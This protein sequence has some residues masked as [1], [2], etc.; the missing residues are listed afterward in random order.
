MD[1]SVAQDGSSILGYADG[2]SLWPKFMIEIIPN[3][4]DEQMSLV[5]ATYDSNIDMKITILCSDRLDNNHWSGFDECTDT[6]TATGYDDFKLSPERKVMAAFPEIKLKFGRRKYKIILS[7]SGNVY[8]NKNTHFLK[9]QNWSF[10]GEK[11]ADFTSLD[12]P[13]KLGRVRIIQTA[14]AQINLKLR[15]QEKA[16]DWAQKFK[17]VT[18]GIT[19]EMRL[20]ERSNFALKQDVSSEKLQDELIFDSLYFLV[21]ESEMTAYESAR[22]KVQVDLST[23]YMPMIFKTSN[24][25]LKPALHKTFNIIQNSEN[26]FNATIN[27]CASNPNYTRCNVNAYCAAVPINS[28]VFSGLSKSDP[29]IQEGQDYCDSDLNL[30]QIPKSVQTLIARFKGANQKLAESLSA[31][32]GNLM[33][34]GP[35]IWMLGGNYGLITSALGSNG[36]MIIGVQANWQASDPIESLYLHELG[37]FFQMFPEQVSSLNLNLKAL[38]QNE[39][40]K[41][42][43]GDAMAVDIAGGALGHRSDLRYDPRPLD[44]NLNYTLPRDFFANGSAIRLLNQYCSVP[45]VETPMKPLCDVLKGEKLFVDIINNLKA[46][47]P[48]PLTESNFFDLQKPIIDSHQIGLPFL[49][50]LKNLSQKEKRPIVRLLNEASESANVSPERPLTCSV[51]KQTKVIFKGSEKMPSM[52]QFKKNFFSY[53]NTRF[54]QE[55]VHSVEREWASRQID[56]GFAYGEQAELRK[57]SDRFC[58]NNAETLWKKFKC[59]YDFFKGCS[60]NI[61]CE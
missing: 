18:P 4:S 38:I 56:T 41:E 14:P 24:K 16:A 35:N 39:F 49:K 21:P 2:E 6:E 27:N 36:N 40:F 5:H 59:G 53:L 57:T 8:L 22:L 52:N 54:S 31:D 29:Q 58:E 10:I 60:C 37:H 15:T 50:L 26:Q 12:L 44:E 48:T 7:L 13:S 46:T 20:N 43:F 28:L 45:P 32:P 33:I 11:A 17:D 25:Y 34:S 51:Y 23:S 55:T 61:T 1:R 9:E 47:D 19:S 3:N 30:N 42:T